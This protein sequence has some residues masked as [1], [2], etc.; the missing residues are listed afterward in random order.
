MRFRTAQL[1]AGHIPIAPFFI[2]VRAGTGRPRLRTQIQ[3]SRTVKDSLSIPHRRGPLLSGFCF[4][5]CI[6]MAKA[7]R[8]CSLAAISTK[9]SGLWNRC[10]ERI[11]SA[12]LVPGCVY[13]LHVVV[14]SRSACNRC[15]CIGYG[16]VRAGIQL[17]V[18]GTSACL[19]VNVV[20]CNGI[21]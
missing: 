14:I 7:N 9:F 17:R 3:R 11:G 2:R 20:A 19:P 12:T 13:A 4:K 18:R 21:R 6:G 16:T 5:H 1:R 10:C 8:L 15:I